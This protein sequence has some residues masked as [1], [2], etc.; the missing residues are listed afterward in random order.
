MQLYILSNAITIFD[1]SRYQQNQPFLIINCDS[2]GAD[3]I[4]DNT[5]QNLTYAYGNVGV[6]VIMHFQSHSTQNYYSVS[7]WEKTTRQSNDYELQ[8]FKI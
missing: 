2:Y 3:L 4:R 8:I 6:D 1:L 5:W 7:T